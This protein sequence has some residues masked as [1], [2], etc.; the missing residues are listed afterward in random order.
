MGP[1]AMCVGFSRLS[2]R[3]ASRAPIA[4]EGTAPPLSKVPPFLPRAP[5]SQVIQ[6]GIGADPGKPWHKEIHSFTFYRLGGEM[7]RRSI[8]EPRVPEGSYERGG[9][10]HRPAFSLA[11]GLVVLPLLL[12]GVCG[13]GCDRSVGGDAPDGGVD[14]ANPGCDPLGD[15]DGDGISNGVEGCLENGTRTGIALPTTGIPTRTTTRFRELPP[16]PPAFRFGSADHSTRGLLRGY[17]GGR[18][19]HGDDLRLSAALGPNVTRVVV[20]YRSYA[21]TLAPCD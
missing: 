10:T 6:A 19:R 7:M 21:F 12:A 4:V 1:G 15:D 11:T 17:P 13:S 16:S 8:V 20:D 3:S 5:R 9:P 18:G 14:A 2:G